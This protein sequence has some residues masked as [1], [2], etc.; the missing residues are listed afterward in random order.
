MNSR[1]RG[2]TAPCCA[3]A[4]GRAGKGSGRAKGG[5]AAANNLAEEQEEPTGAGAARRSL[6]PAAWA[7]RCARC[8]VGAGRP[9]ERCGRPRTGAGTCCSAGRTRASFA[10]VYTRPQAARHAPLQPSGRCPAAVAT[11]PRRWALGAGWRGM[12]RPLHARSGR[13]KPVPRLQHTHKTQI[14]LPSDRRRSARLQL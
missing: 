1:S 14:T 8:D 3:W 11:Q 12:P 7:A 2:S 4:S 6:R 10:M 5:H 9:R 13:N